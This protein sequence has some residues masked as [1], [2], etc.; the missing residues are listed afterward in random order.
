MITLQLKLMIKKND[1][2]LIPTNKDGFIKTFLFKINLEQ[3]QS[4]LLCDNTKEDLI[5]SLHKDLYFL[6]FLVNLDFTEDAH[7]TAIYFEYKSKVYDYSYFDD[8]YI[9]EYWSDEP[10]G[11]LDEDFARVSSYGY[12]YD[13]YIDHFGMDDENFEFNI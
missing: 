2:I 3:L 13:E 10:K 9:D 1:K 11:I 5:N 6:N 12:E 8:E 4:S 7:I